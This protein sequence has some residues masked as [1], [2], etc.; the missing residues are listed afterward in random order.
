MNLNPTKQI[1][2]ILDFTQHYYNSL[3]RKE[4]QSVTSYT[5]DF[6]VLSASGAEGNYQQYFHDDMGSPTRLV[7]SDRIGKSHSFDEFGN[8]ISFNA[9]DS[10]LINQPFTYTGYQRDEITG[11]YYAQAREYQP[12]VGRFI[13]EDIHWNPENMIFGDEKGSLPSLEAILQSGNLYSYTI[14][15]PLNFI[16]PDGALIIKIA[17]GGF[18]FFV[19]ISKKTAVSAGVV[20]VHAVAYGASN[21]VDQLIIIADPDNDKT[22][23]DFDHGEVFDALINGTFI[24]LLKVCGAKTGVIIIA[25]IAIN[26]DT[27]KIEEKGMYIFTA[28]VMASLLM[29][30]VESKLGPGAKTFIDIFGDVFVSNMLKNSLKAKFELLMANKEP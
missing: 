2:D 9:N 22:I 5:W 18:L 11:T 8:E 3:Q 15:N 21:A 7:N 24:G 26:I 25:G 14:N 13:S 19:T 23:H 27:G 12:Q 10:G 4:N 6:N 30:A 17:V 28:D 16:D 1:E 29:A 20:L